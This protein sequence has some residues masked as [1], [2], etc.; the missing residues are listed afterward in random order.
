[1]PGSKEKFT[2]QRR[3]GLWL[4]CCFLA[5]ACHYK[6]CLAEGDGLPSSA[7]VTRTESPLLLHTNDQRQQPKAGLLFLLQLIGPDCH[8][9][10]Q[11]LP[12]YLT[13]A[14]NNLLDTAR[15]ASISL[16]NFTSPNGQ[17]PQ[18]GSVLLEPKK[19]AAASPDD[20]ASISASWMQSALPV[21]ADE[22]PHHPFRHSVLRK[23]LQGMNSHEPALMFLYGADPQLE[24]SAVH[25]QLSDLV[26]SGKLGDA[27]RARGI[28]LSDVHLVAFEPM[29]GDHPP[30]G[31][32]DML[33]YSEHGPAL[34]AF[35][36]DHGPHGHHHLH[37]LHNVYLPWALLTGVLSCLTVGLIFKTARHCCRC[38]RRKQG[39]LASQLSELAS[40]S[41]TFSNPLVAKAP[42]TLAMQAVGVIP[43]SDPDWIG[44]VPWSDWQID[45]KDILLCRRPDGRLWELGAGASAKVYRALKSGVQVVA[46]KV[47]Q[48]RDPNSSSSSS[49]SSSYAASRAA[50]RS[51]VF[52]QEIAILKSCHDR[53]IVQFIGACLQPD[54]TLMV[55]EYLEGG[56]LYHAIANDSIGRFSWYKRDPVNGTK[57]PGMG[58]RIALDVAR[59]LHFL[60][61]RKIVHF[62]LKSANILLARD[63]TAKIADVGL[64]KIMQQQFLSTLYCVGTFAWAAPEVLLGKACCTEK[65]DMYSYGVVL[66]E[67]CTGESPSGRQLRSVRVP[68]ECPQDVADVIANCLDE[69]PS[70]RPSA[71]DIIDGLG[72]IRETRTSF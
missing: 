14:L 56:D 2:M 31:I 16:L 67:L 50:A 52:K 22:Q 43:K 71:R 35:H 11:E 66:W 17:L 62:D 32:A 47:F 44:N 51:D 38:R 72:A 64:A 57:S 20:L 9:S 42:P 19:S 21:L 12:Q 36:P 46:A 3:S 53:N 27:V 48:E 54:C 70:S 34:A 33:G 24:M 63:N 61:S 37:L 60:H 68:E 69:N 6:S 15:P 41:D 65:V 1:M 5:A 10:Q 39:T 23:L 18:P 30:F 29:F 45:Q 49:S 25:L 40:Q 55:M 4:A 7:E 26:A 58:R 59:G 8:L 28:K 13:K